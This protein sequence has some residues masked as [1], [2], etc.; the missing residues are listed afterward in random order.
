M[1]HRLIGDALI[2]VVKGLIM[3]NLNKTM[4]SNI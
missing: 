3:G 4:F 2:Y 1:E